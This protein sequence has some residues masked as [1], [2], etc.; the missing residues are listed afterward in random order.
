MRAASRFALVALLAVITI[1]GAI[2]YERVVVRELA[3][4]RALNATRAE[5]AALKEK[6]RKQR[7]TIERLSDPRGAVPEIH[8]RLHLVSGREELIYVKGAESPAPEMRP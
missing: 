5:V 4:S 3:L 7:R 2:Q 8:D 6:E 1:E